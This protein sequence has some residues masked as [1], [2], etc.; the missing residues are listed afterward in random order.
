[1]SDPPRYIGGDEIP[2]REDAGSAARRRDEDRWLK[3]VDD[4]AHT[5]HHDPEWSSEQTHAGEFG[6][7]N[8][9]GDPID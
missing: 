9:F 8:Q 1:V 2:R 7:R 4:A 5:G 3:A 6:A